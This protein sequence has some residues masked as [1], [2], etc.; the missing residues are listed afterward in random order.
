MITTINAE[1]AKLT[2]L[3]HGRIGVDFRSGRPFVLVEKGGE[4]DAL[5]SALETLRAARAALEQNP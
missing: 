3:T 2:H 1:I 4:W 5:V